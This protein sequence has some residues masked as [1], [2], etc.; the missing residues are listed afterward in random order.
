MSKVTEYLLREGLSLNELDL[1]II[2]NIAA[3]R[4]PRRDS[5]SE[6]AGLIQ[7]WVAERNQGHRDSEEIRELISVY[8]RNNATFTVNDGSVFSET[9]SLTSQVEAPVVAVSARGSF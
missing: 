2:S 9:T 5:A 7:L 1:W 4:P 8:F 6:L 3:F